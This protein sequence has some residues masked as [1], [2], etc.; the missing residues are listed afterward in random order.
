MPTAFDNL[1]EA[2]LG[3]LVAALEPMPGHQHKLRLGKPLG[4]GT[5]RLE[6]AQCL[7]VDRELRYQGRWEK[8]APPQKED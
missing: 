4:L 6:L 5:V 2:E 7:V 8:A 1:T 3:L